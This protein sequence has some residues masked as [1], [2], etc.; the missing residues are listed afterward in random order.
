MTASTCI[1]VVAKVEAQRSTRRVSLLTVSE[2]F[3]VYR[4][5]GAVAPR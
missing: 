2:L 3:R 4:L 1:V 5:A